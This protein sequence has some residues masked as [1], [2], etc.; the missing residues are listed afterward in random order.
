MEAKSC[1]GISRCH[2]S[3]RQL[4]AEIDPSTF[5]YPV[6]VFSL[7]CNVAKTFLCEELLRCHEQVTVVP[8]W[9][10]KVRAVTGSGR[11]GLVAQWRERAASPAVESQ[12]V[13]RPASTAPSV[14][15][16]PDPLGSLVNLSASRSSPRLCHSVWSCSALSVME[17]SWKVAS[18]LT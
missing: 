2:E 1:Q 17:V 4:P 18:K 15:H 5:C 9:D 10:R 11:R 14:S 16:L 7:P 6:L 3:H 8:V 13:S 12:L